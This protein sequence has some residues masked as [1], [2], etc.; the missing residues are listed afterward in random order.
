L[1][2]DEV[3]LADSVQFTRDLDELSSH[4]SPRIK[5]PGQKPEGYYFFEAET[6]AGTEVGSSVSLWERTVSA[7]REQHAY[8]DEQFFWVALG[9]ES[10]D[11]ALDTSMLHA[12][13]STIEPRKQYRLL[14]YH[15]QPRDGARPNS[16]MEVS[17]GNLLQSI[18]PPDTKIDSRY[19]LKSWWF[20]TGDNAQRPQ[21]TWLRIRTADAWDMDFTVIIGPSYWRPVVSGALVAVPAILALATQALELTTKISLGLVG[22]AVGILSS[23]LAS[24]R[25]ETK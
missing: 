10:P 18:A 3:V 5:E 6:P 17:W 21:P 15:F 11:T 7:L 9:I 23:F 24:S 14:I 12:W 1:I 4:V 19:D 8:K 20:S 25:S 13:P 16:R 2:V 22:V